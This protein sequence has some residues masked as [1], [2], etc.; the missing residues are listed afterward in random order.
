MVSSSSNEEHKMMLTV[1]ELDLEEGEAGA[2][3]D[4]SLLPVLLD[5][6]DVMKI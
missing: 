6:E 5:D 4:A 1:D 3:N 2:I